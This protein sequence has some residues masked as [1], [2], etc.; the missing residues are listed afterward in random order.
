MKPSVLLA[1]STLA[2]RS[3]LSLRQHDGQ[4]TLRI[5]GETLMSTKACAS[6]Q[7]MAELA[8]EALGPQ[9]MRRVL[10]GGFGFGF[11]VRR[12][13][14]L[15]GPQVQVDVA[16]LL[17]QIVD[18]NRQHLLEVNGNLVD[19]PR[20]QLH[21]EDVQHVLA[22]AQPQTYDAI[23]VDVD[24]GP[25]AFVDRRNQRMYANPGIRSVFQALRPGGRAVYWS[26]VRDDYFAIK[27]GHAGFRVQVIAAKAYPEAKRA[28][29]TLFCADRAG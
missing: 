6:E 9:R 19:D 13:L 21:L 24:N 3:V 22:A 4:Y 10:V 7:R 5:D 23:L 2:D 16:E 27:L 28:S 25:A 17:P 12:V 14:E 29:H 18:W 1:E 11:T 20:V 8:F 15:C 26:A